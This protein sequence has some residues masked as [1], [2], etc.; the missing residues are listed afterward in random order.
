MAGFEGHGAQSGSPSLLDG[1]KVGRIRIFTD[2]DRITKDNVIMVLN[3]ALQLHALNRQRMAEL[4]RYDMNQVELKRKKKF[5]QDIDIQDFDAIA[6]QIVEFKLGYNWG[7]PILFIYD[8]EFSEG[9]EETD[10]GG[11]VKKDDTAISYVNKLNALEHCF[12]KDQALGRYVE[13]TGIGYQMVGFKRYYD[14][15]EDQSPF[16]L[17]TLDPM[18]TFIVYKNDVSQR[19]M[20]GVT[21]RID[22]NGVGY[23]DCYT[24]DQIFYVRDRVTIVNDTKQ[25]DGKY[26]GDRSGNK[27]LLGAIPI[28]ECIRSYDRTGVF[29]KVIPEIDALNI[30]LSDTCNAVSQT[31]QTIWWGND[32]E[33]PMDENGQPKKPENGDVVNTR[34]TPGGH[35]PIFQ[36]LNAEFDYEGVQEHIADKRNNILQKCYVPNQV[37]VGGG[38]TG[39]AYSMS[40]GWSAAETVALKQENLTRSFK[41]SI[42]ELEIKAIKVMQVYAD[43]H[44]LMS[45]KLSD[46]RPKFTREK[47]FDVGTKVNA[48]A[49]LL[50]IGIDGRTAMQSIGLFP[51]VEQAWNKSRDMIELMQK[52]LFTKDDSSMSAESGA[53]DNFKTHMQ[54]E[55]D[56]SSNSPS[57]GGYNTVRE[58]E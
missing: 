4:F 10:K 25:I 7:N 39:L 34:T 54:D 32:F 49:T 30:L 29:E 24:D 56:Q 44:P 35:T 46:V 15:N 21:Y 57:I 3:E 26:L 33:F 28:R 36:A 19:P 11:E 50:R 23:Y 58:E 41:M 16:D 40:S 18:F 8:D 43:D 12:D 53:S 48:L 27:N 42:L 22:R 37:G 55:S 5:R 9:D 52:N 17:Y 38:S 2:Q 51:D 47:T 14:A 1:Y 6:S 20:M 31:V 45:L 13:I